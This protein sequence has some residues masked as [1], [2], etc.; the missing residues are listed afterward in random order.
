MAMAGALRRE[1]VLSRSRMRKRWPDRSA[2]ERTAPPG[3]SSTA[4]SRFGF[5]GDRPGGYQGAGSRVRVWRLA[6]W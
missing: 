3:V 1:A 4:S 5:G 2:G 6:K